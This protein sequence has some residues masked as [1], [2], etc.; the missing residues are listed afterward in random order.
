MATETKSAMKSQAK[1]ADV[2]SYGND[3]FFV[4]KA[5]ESKAF[6]EMHGFPK[7]LLQQK[8]TLGKSNR[9]IH[10]GILINNQ[11]LD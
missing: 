7:A 4:K 9:R 11:H 8:R 6:L 1:I 3:P 2:K 10:S 5:Q